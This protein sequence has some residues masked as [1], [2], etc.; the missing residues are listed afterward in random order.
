[1][2][3][4]EMAEVRRAVGSYDARELAHALA[5]V[6]RY[7]ALAA[8]YPV[9]GPHDHDRTTDAASALSALVRFLN[10]ATRTTGGTPH[11]G[12]LDRIVAHVEAPPA[13]C[14]R[15]PARWP[16]VLTS[17]PQRLGSPAT[18]WPTRT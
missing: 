10:Y 12:T 1:M 7:N 17:S 2:A 15:R 11:P 4:I 5:E 6:D 3:R 13:G 18:A 14:S 8:M 16:S 9:D